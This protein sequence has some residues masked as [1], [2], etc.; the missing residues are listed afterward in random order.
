MEQIGLF[1]GENGNRGTDLNG[2]LESIVENPRNDENSEKINEISKKMGKNFG[3]KKEYLN[4][5]TYNELR[6][7]FQGMN[8]IEIPEEMSKILNPLERLAIYYSLNYIKERDTLH[9]KC[10]KCEDIMEIS[11]IINKIAFKTTDGFGKL[12]K[13]IKKDSYKTAF[14]KGYKKFETEPYSLQRRLNHLPKKAIKTFMESFGKQ[15]EKSFAQNS[16][17]GAYSDPNEDGRSKTI[18]KQRIFD[19][20]KKDY[21]SLLKTK[22]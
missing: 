12:S 4:S 11:K 20:V 9:D 18:Y 17:E 10:K 7:I 6:Y 19:K 22:K 13:A 21:N 15:Y 16:L 14:K 1:D 3:F 8:N 5:F 2:L